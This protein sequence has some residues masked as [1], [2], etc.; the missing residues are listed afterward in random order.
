ME[1]LKT[2]IWIVN[3]FSSLAIIALVLMQHGRGA[4]AGAS[5]G[6]SGSAQ[7]V[8]GSGGNANFLSR[9]TGMAATVFFASCLLLGY[10]HSQQ[11]NKGLDFSTVQQSSIAP[12]AT[13]AADEQGSTLNPVAAHA[14]AEAS[15]AAAS[16][17]AKATNDDKGSALAAAAAGA[18]AG[19]AAAKL[20]DTKKAETDK[21]NNKN[22]DDAK[23]DAKA[24]AG[25][26]KKPTKAD[27]DKNKKKSSSKTKQ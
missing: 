27:A 20:A 21:K 23:K 11:S 10:I 17:E 26:S 19:A 8:F 1:A 7:G 6:G 5:F 2:V 25:K 18:T 3:I 13:P 4:D 22:N 14:S 9:M 24:P 16:G 12:A 15:A